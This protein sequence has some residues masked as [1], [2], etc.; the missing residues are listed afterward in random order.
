MKLKS[1][2]VK[3]I[4]V[5][6]RELRILQPSSLKS[7]TDRSLEALKKSM[8][9]NDFVCTF[10]VWQDS[11]G[12]IWVLD[13]T[14]R[15]KVL[16]AL[17]AE[18]HTV[19]D[20]FTANFIDCANRQEAANLVLVFSS[21]YAKISQDGLDKFLEIEG[22]GFTADTLDLPGVDIS[23]YVPQDY[24]REGGE[25]TGEYSGSKSSPFSKP[26]KHMCP[27]CGS[28]DILPVGMEKDS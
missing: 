1:R 8:L 5:K 22:I 7:F 10:Q 17:E 23:K 14:H 16:E 27:K 20:E 18:G 19:P 15:I 26:S 4:P 11:D 21:Q 12:V 6:W 25:Y 28:T 3:S 2:I 13:G 24:F 9:E